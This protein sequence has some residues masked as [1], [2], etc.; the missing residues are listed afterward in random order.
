MP[1]YSQSAYRHGDFVAKYGVFPLGKKQI[2]RETEQIKE[3]DPINIISQQVQGLPQEREGDL[4]VL[5][6]NASEPR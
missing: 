2:E 5:R 6:A 1:E 3:S 4:R